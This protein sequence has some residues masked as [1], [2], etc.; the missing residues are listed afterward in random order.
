[1]ILIAY[2]IYVLVF[3]IWFYK[4]ALKFNLNPKN[5]SIIGAILSIVVL[6]LFVILFQVFYAYAPTYNALRPLYHWLE[7]IG[8]NPFAATMIFSSLAMVVFRYL[9]F[10]KD[11]DT[12]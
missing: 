12:V 3:G 2:L 10:V 1:M 9:L 6:V 5:W 7:Y 11:D 8:I 4:S